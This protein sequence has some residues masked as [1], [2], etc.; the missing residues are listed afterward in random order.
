MTLASF[1]SRETLDERKLRKCRWRESDERGDRLTPGKG[2]LTV[3]WRAASARVRRAEQIE[4]EGNDFSY[5]MEYCHPRRSSA[6]YPRLN[7]HHSFSS[8]SF[9]STTNHEEETDDVFSRRVVRR[10]KGQTRDFVQCVDMF[11]RDTER[12]TIRPMCACRASPKDAK[13][14]H[15]SLLD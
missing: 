8:P 6:K 13:F 9:F 1:D 4:G 2:F 7:N 15:S 12:R 10:D 11:L 3:P 14:V 5:Q